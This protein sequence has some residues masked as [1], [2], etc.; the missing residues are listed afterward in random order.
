MKTDAPYV[1]AQGD[2]ESWRLDCDYIAGCDGFHG[3]ARQSISSD[4]LN[5]FERV[6]PFGWLG[7][8]ADTPPVRRTGLCQTRACG[9][10]PVASARLPEAVI[11]CRSRC[12]KRSRTGLI[13]VFGTN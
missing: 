2:G 1:I 6:Y 8:L 11:T 4:A 10:A 3:V 5:I 13:S 9:F 12:R 7:V